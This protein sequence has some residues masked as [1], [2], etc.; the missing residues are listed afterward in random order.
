MV[1]YGKDAIMKEHAGL[2]KNWW[3]ERRGSLDLKQAVPGSRELIAFV[4]FFP[5]KSQASQHYIYNHKTM[6][7][8]EIYQAVI[9]LEKNAVF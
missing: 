1:L 9:F 8:Y 6:G 7:P 5:F 3:R 4:S 2:L